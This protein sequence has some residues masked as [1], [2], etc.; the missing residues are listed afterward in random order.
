MEYQEYIEKGEVC[1]DCGLPK[2]TNNSC[3]S[4]EMFK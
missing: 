3:W 2:D 4:C 1:N